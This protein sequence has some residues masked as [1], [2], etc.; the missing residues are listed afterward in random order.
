MLFLY[1]GKHNR[2]ECSNYG[3]ITLFSVPG[4]VYSH[5]LLA[6]IKSHVQQL[7]C[8][9]QSGFT[10][11]WFYVSWSGDYALTTVGWRQ[12]AT[13]ISLATSN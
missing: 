3:G 9:E 7:C 5:V 11:D 8:T 1:K 12:V 13:D 6:R 2:Y 10:T 4:K